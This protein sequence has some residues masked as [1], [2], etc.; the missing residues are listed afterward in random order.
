MASHT[1]HIRRIYSRPWRNG[2]LANPS[3]IP[4]CVQVGVR[5]ETTGALETMF[6]PCSQLPAGRASLAGV[7]R[8]HVLDHDPY[9]TSLVFDKALELPER[10]AVQPC[11]H[12][13]TCPQTRADV[14]EVLQHDL[15]SPNTA[16]FLD[17]GLARLAARPID[18]L[19]RQDVNHIQHNRLFIRKV[20]TLHAIDPLTKVRGFLT[21]TQ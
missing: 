16:G 15:S 9:S 20:R 11:A 12:A 17:N 6:T 10:P 7:S 5:P 1:T 19:V 21:E 8:I 13:P 3:Q 4:T 14:S 18:V 2:S